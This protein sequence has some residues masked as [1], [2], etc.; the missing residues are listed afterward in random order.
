MNLSMRLWLSMAAIVVAVLQMDGL[1]RA[2]EQPSGAQIPLPEQ[3]SPRVAPRAVPA[4]PLAA[5]AQEAVEISQRRFLDADVHTPWQIMHGI[6]AYRDKYEIKL[7]GEKIN[8]LQWVASGPRFMMRDQETGKP[9]KE[10]DIGEPWWEKTEHGGRGHR[11]TVP[12]AFEGHPNQ[13]AAIMTLSTLPPD[14]TF[15]TPD[16]PITMADIVHNAQMEV[17]TD[18]EI[19]WTLWFLC[20]YVEPDA[21]WLNR[22]GEPWSM[23]RL[24]RL[25]TLEPPYNAPCGGTHG[26]FALCRSRNAYL[27]T[28]RPLRGVWLEADQKIKRYV[29][30]ARAYQ[31]PDGTFSASFFKGKNHSSDF[32]T[33]LGTS[34][35]TLEFL[36]V[37]LSDEE[38]KQEWVRRGVQAIARE[39]I[40][41][42]A[43][44]AECGALYHALDALVIYLERVSGRPAPTRTPVWV[45]TAGVEQRTAVPGAEINPVSGQT[46]PVSA[47]PVPESDE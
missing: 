26:L 6:L 42:K 3:G 27:S 10:G 23:E 39:L 12:Y 47:P 36:M 11:Y 1:V 16:G 17:S 4:D 21:S 5:L 2:D 31:N 45:P 19:T 15:Q 38:L 37:A 32:K 20:F 41:H 46:E 28:G 25:Q 7:K 35:H 18:E 34:G 29:A 40:D 24:V 14:F 9:L 8:A 22:H 43:D 13:F 30:E 44:P 33:R